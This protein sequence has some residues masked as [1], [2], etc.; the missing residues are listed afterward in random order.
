[1][2]SGVSQFRIMEISAYLTGSR[3]ELLHRLYSGSHHKAGHPFPADPRLF[4]LQ[5]SPF[6][7]PETFHLH[8][9]RETETKKRT[10]WCAAILDLLSCVLGVEGV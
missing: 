6:E 9:K 5:L 1:M 10:D 8:R 4:T 7:T 2:N 3:S